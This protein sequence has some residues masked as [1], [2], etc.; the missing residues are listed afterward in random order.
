MKRRAKQAGRVT[1]F[2]LIRVGTICV[3]IMAA[4]W[5]QRETTKASPAN[6][7]IVA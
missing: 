1:A 2:R 4:L 3:G 5:Q 7:D 6:T